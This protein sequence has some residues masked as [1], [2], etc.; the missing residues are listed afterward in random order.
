M[1][2]DLIETLKTSIYSPSNTNNTTNI[3]CFHCLFSK[4]NMLQK[5]LV[6]NDQRFMLILMASFLFCIFCTFCMFFILLRATQPNK[7]FCI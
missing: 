5:F 2:M 6:Q 4:I 1:T 3:Y 7:L